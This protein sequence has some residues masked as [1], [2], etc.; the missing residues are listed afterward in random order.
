MDISMSFKELDPAL[1]NQMISINERF[2]SQNEKDQIWVVTQ[3]NNMLVGARE[4]ETQIENELLE[5]GISPKDQMLPPLEHLKS[6]GKTLHMR[7]GNY[8]DN[9]GSL[10]RAVQDECGKQFQSLI[11]Q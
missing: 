11:L 7:I 1:Y 10:E 6:E 4:L 9:L 2:L 8:R 3:R 5:Q